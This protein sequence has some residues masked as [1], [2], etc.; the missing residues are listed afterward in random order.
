MTDKWDHFSS[1]GIPPALSPENA[2]FA[3]RI[4]PLPTPALGWI[5]RDQEARPAFI[6]R[7]QGSSITENSVPTFQ[8]IE[9]YHACDVE[10]QD[11]N[12][13]GYVKAS[14]VLCKSRDEKTIALFERCVTS[15]ISQFDAPLSTTEIDALVVKLRDLFGGLGTT[16][17]AV[18]LG[19]WGE[20]FAIHGALDADAALICWRLRDTSKFDFGDGECRIDVKTTQQR[21]RTH[22]VSHAQ[23][24]PAGRLPAFI[25]S[26]Q[27]ERQR[28]GLSIGDLW[29]ALI[30]RHPQH[31]DYIDKTVVKTLGTDW[32]SARNISYDASAARASFAVYDTSD[33]NLDDALQPPIVS[34]DYTIDFGQLQP[35]RPVATSPALMRALTPQ[36]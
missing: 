17:D 3:F 32:E 16:S 13:A 11:S 35:A 12:G 14:V 29:D 9:I 8:H 33:I 18:A 6:L 15:A 10:I 22:T 24:R 19:L 25:I 27:T 20:L 30:S 36:R 2:A 34:V 23:L 21:M 4:R 1:A 28:V 31:Q 5:G 7:I 26:I